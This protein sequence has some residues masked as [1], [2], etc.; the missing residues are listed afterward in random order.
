[1]RVCV[2]VQS[3]SSLLNSL[4]VHRSV[5]RLLPVESFTVRLEVVLV[6]AVVRLAARSVVGDTELG[7]EEAVDGG[8]E[9]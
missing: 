2:C 7:E 6:V 4:L 1:M 5:C 8:V 3:R 9:V